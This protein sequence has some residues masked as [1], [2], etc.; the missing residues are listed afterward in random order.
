MREV[1][2]IG[3]RTPTVAIPTGAQRRVQYGDQV[4]RWLDRGFIE[5]V[6]W[7]DEEPDLGNPPDESEPEVVEVSGMRFHAVVREPEEPFESET[8]EDE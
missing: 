1:T 7:H 2:V 3:S 8:V 4:Q 6:E 5:V